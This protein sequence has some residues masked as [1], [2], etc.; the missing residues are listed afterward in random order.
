MNNKYYELNYAVIKKENLKM[1]N[2]LNN[3]ILIKFTN[4]KN[5]IVE[6]FME[7]Y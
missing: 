2:I 1:F 3:N 5:E 6:R 7:L 4:R